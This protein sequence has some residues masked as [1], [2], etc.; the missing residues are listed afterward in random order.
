MLAL[1][2][3]GLA[4]ISLVIAL[5]LL[6]DQ[7]AHDVRT[8]DPAIWKS[9]IAFLVAEICE[10]TAYL[11]GGKEPLYQIAV[12]A[13]FAAIICFLRQAIWA[14]KPTTLSHSRHH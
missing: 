3:T 13:G 5:L 10:M 9:A 4:V 11:S 1:S 8:E 7:G 6:Y 14:V 12:L 2:A